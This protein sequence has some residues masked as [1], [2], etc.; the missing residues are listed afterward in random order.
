MC[1]LFALTK[2]LDSVLLSVVSIWSCGSTKRT[3][4]NLCL[5]LTR[6][7]LW[8]HEFDVSIFLLKSLGVYP[9]QL[10]FWS[11][12][13]LAAFFLINNGPLK[14]RVSGL[15]K[16]FINTFP[17]SFLSSLHPIHSSFRYVGEK[18]FGIWKDVDWYC[19]PIF[20]FKNW[21]WFIVWSIPLRHGITC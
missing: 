14:G 12:C 13:S 8:G 20:L 18:F 19:W 1:Y 9:C 17:N 15:P 5:C 3:G 6:V 16:F 21:R 10:L 11:N 2:W 4:F 7:N